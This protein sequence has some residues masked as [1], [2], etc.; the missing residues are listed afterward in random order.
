MGSTANGRTEESVY[1]TLQQ[2]KVPSLNNK[3]TKRNKQSL[4]PLWVRNRR[5]N[6]GSP[7]SQKERR[8]R[9]G[10]KKEFER[11]MAENFPNV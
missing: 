7:E 2:Q 4:R 9:V 6:T 1:L 11:T 3:E 10:M 5:P 8:E